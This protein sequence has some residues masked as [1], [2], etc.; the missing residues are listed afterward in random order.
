MPRRLPRALQNLTPE[1]R[2]ALAKINP[3]D[4]TFVLAYANP[5]APTH[6]NG[7]Q[8]YLLAHPEA[9]L[10]TAASAAWRRARQANV[11]RAMTAVLES[12]GAGREVR[13][14]R[15]AALLDTSH[16]VVSKTTHRN[17]EG[18]V[19]HIVETEAPVRP[20]A[21]LRGVDLLNRM[22]GLYQEQR[23]AGDLAREAYYRELDT[24]LPPPQTGKGKA[25][26]PRRVRDTAARDIAEGEP[27]TRA[28]EGA[29][30]GEPP[31][32]TAP[33]RPG[34]EGGSGSSLPT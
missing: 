32:T 26:R 34:G 14:E 23:V 18:N 4:Q 27:D 12:V 28:T 22:D 33:A 19:T 17:A 3:S 20:E 16:T 9:G 7:T 25:R 30:E 29:R 24:L 21:V 1:A 8:S 10:T 15:V 5:D 31:P 2:A 6:G 11:S 13:A